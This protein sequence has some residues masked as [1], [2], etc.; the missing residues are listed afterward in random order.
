M[1]LYS[2]AHVPRTMP[3]RPGWLYVPAPAGGFI[4]WEGGHAPSIQ[5]DHVDGP[6]LRFSDGQLHWLTLWER[7]LFALG[8]TDAEKL[9]RKHRPNLC[10]ATE[11]GDGKNA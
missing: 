3:G 8:R 10:A 1:K 4:G 5:P 11:T 6:L 2:D 7:L 9:Q